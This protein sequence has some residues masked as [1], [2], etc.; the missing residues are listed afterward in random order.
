VRKQAG[1]EAAGD[2]Q[3]FD[4]ARPVPFTL[5]LIVILPLPFAPFA[6]FADNRAYRRA[7]PSSA[8]AAA[9]MSASDGSTSNAAPASGV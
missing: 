8:R 3:V 5:P 9:T 7:D 6:S 4:L 2:R 1:G